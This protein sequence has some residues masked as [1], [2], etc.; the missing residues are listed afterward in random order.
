[1]VEGS[2][3]KILGYVWID[4]RRWNGT[5]RSGMEQNKIS[6]HRL[7]VLLS[8]WKGMSYKILFI[9]YPSFKKYFTIISTYILSLIKKKKKYLCPI[10]AMNNCHN[11]T[12]LFTVLGKMQKIMVTE[13]PWQPQENILS[14]YINVDYFLCFTFC[15]IVQW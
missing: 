11:S 15:S 7:D 10:T 4:G 3:V 9:Y 14:C 8:G 5:E 2:R 1:M 6:F 13:S 12:T